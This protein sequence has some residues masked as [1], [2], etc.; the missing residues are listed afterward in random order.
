MSSQPGGPDWW[1]AADGRW[2]P[3]RPPDQPPAPGWWLAA[4][5]RWYPPRPP[6]RPPAP[7]WWLAADGRWYPPAGNDNGN[8]ASG[9]PS[10]GVAPG[11]A[12][13][14]P[15]P[16]PV[17]PPKPVKKVVKKV[18]KKKVVKKAAP[19]AGPTSGR[20]R[21][22]APAKT[23]APTEPAA[24]P[25]ATAKPSRPPRMDSLRDG[26]PA[27]PP[28][29][30]EPGPPAGLVHDDVVDELAETGPLAPLGL[31]ELGSA[32]TQIAKQFE[33]SRQDAEVLATARFNAALRA[34]GRFATEIE[35]EFGEESAEEPQEEAAPSASLPTSPPPAPSAAPPAASVPSPP[36]ASMPPPGPLSSAPAPTLSLSHPERPPETDPVLLTLGL[37]KLGAD[38][39]HIGDRILIH[40]DRVEVRDR[41][42]VLRQVVH[43]RDMTGVSI[44]KRI[45]GS[46]LEVGSAV[47]DPIIAK[48]VRPDLAEEAR[49]L[50]AQLV[51]EFRP[52]PRDRQ[53]V[54]DR[55]I[56]Q[57][58]LLRKLTDLHRAG[59]L[60]ADEYAEKKELVARLARG[61]QLTTT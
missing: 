25:A 22:E 2:Y 40:S 6:E 5:G 51:G 55:Q 16:Q 4:D 47:G 12:E 42:N 9:T 49:D 27:S 23:S 41:N 52:H 15:T 59:V 21:P 7:G 18:I 48:G 3:P 43:N 24:A 8:G 37:S 44:S 33:A 36:P 46:I 11:P 35:A 39:D 14:S 20:S 54:T 26:G 29:A 61:D 60:T 31:D 56:D 58:D 57:T 13:G 19:A 10:V 50:I 38:L 28:P 34:L 45:T 32:G 53:R 17:T 30:A 1:E